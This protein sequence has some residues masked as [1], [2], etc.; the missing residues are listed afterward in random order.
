LRLAVR[1][2]Q[3]RLRHNADRNDEAHPENDSVQLRGYLADLDDVGIVIAKDLRPSGVN[4]HRQLY[5]LLFP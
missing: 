5:N 3:T 4:S 2:L 1:A